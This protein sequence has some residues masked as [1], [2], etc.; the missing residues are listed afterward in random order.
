M[1]ES[2]I[3]GG[4]DWGGGMAGPDRYAMRGAPGADLGDTG[5]IGDTTSQ[6]KL[7]GEWGITEG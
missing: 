7:T 4:D 6:P 2:G 3:D 1:G 5:W